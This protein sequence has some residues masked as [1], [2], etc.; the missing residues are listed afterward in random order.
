MIGP[1]LPDHEKALPVYM[2]HRAELLDYAA[3]IVG[4]RQRAE[5]VVQDAYLRFGKALGRGPLQQPAGYLFRIVRN[6]SVD[7][8]RRSAFEKELINSETQMDSVKGDGP[9]PEDEALHKDE[10]KIVMDALAE[11]PAPA[12]AALK[13]HRVEGLK[14]K[15]IAAELG[16]SIAQA[17]A[18][19]FQALQHCRK[20]LKNAG[21]QAKFLV[22]IF[23]FDELQ[24][25]F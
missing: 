25:F 18:L 19:I 1:A 10:L 21:K 3:G 6:L 23:F 13:M 15:E 16:I 22:L 8:F 11:L 9:S 20:R 4:C 2:A 17:H 5:D 12:R 14:L 24:F 7:F